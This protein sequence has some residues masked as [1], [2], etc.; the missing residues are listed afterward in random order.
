[1]FVSS[2]DRLI[3]SPS[4]SAIPFDVGIADVTRDDLE[5]EVLDNPLVGDVS[6]IDERTACRSTGSTV[7]GHAVEDLRGSLDIGIQEGRLPRTPDEITLGLRAAQDLDVERRRHRHG[8]AAP[9]ATS[10]SSRWSA[11]AVVPTFNGEELGLNALLTP[12]GLEANATAAP[13]TGAAVEV[14]PGEDV[15]ELT[16]LLA[17]QF[18]A[19]AQ[20]V[21]V[22]VQNLEQLGGLP[23]GVAAIV[24]SI[25][26]LAL[27]NALVVAVRRRRRD[28]AVL[29]AMGFT[30]RQTA[31]S[32][33]VMALAI[34]AIGVL[35]GVPV[36]MAIGATL[37]RVD[38]VGRLRAVGR[39]LPVGAAAAA[40]GRRRASSPS[41][42]R[43]SRL[44]RPPPRAPPRVSGPSSAQAGVAARPRAGG[45]GRGRAPPCSRRPR[46]PRS[47][48]PAG[49]SSRW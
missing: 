18:E 1:M 33:V 7:D 24:G 25:A 38:R 9:T 29:R 23:A 47:R 13:F 26:V 32:V 11:S 44:A 42:P 34:V 16:E 4:R 48:P 22:A 31:I 45:G 6:V 46:S 15:D 35:V 40:G 43:P 5:D 36:G 41:S 21:P 17:S 12:E 14:A 2:L 19:D 20:A 49:R 10:A 27:A 28:L 8:A 37:W 3:A 39:L 30:R